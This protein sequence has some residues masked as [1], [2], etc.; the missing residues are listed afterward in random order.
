VWFQ[1]GQLELHV[2]CRVNTQHQRQAGAA[3][4]AACR[5][6]PRQL[7][8]VEFSCSSTYS[9]ELLPNLTMSCAV[10]TQGLERSYRCTAR[11]AIGPDYTRT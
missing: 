1:V 5:S 4:P 7:T 8:P 2:A 3:P 9:L 10:Q 11:C 6:E